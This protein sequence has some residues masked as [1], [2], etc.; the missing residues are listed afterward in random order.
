MDQCSINNVVEQRKGYFFLSLSYQDSDRYTADT[1][2]N[3]STFSYVVD[4]PPKVLL[5]QTLEDLPVP[6]L[7]GCTCSK[8]KTTSSNI[9]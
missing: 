9:Y 2:L 5:K 6:C 3:K 8:A 1:L 7:H 4:F